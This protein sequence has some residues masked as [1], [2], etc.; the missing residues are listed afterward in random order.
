MPQTIDT[1]A[2]RAAEIATLVSYAHELHLPSEALNQTVFE[3]TRDEADMAIAAGEKG[4]HEAYDDA[5]SLAEQI[6][7]EGLNAQITTISLDCGESATRRLFEA[8]AS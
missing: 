7:E 1:T 8:L 5:D 2:P 6:N 4:G 3:I